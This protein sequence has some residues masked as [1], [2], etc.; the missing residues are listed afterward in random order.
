MQRMN[1]RHIPEQKE[2]NLMS[3]GFVR[4]AFGIESSGIEVTGGRGSRVSP[5]VTSQSAFPKPPADC[6][7]LTPS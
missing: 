5:I 7:L 2:D 1:D 6:S 3:V 4:N